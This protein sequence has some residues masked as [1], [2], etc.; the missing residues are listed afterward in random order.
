MVGL[1]VQGYA[2]IAR[3]KDGVQTIFFM[4]KSSISEKDYFIAWAIFFV[5]ALV[6][7]MIAGFIGG[8]IIGGAM[9]VAG[10][11]PG[12][13]R[14]AGAMVGFL[15]SLPISYITFRFVVGKFVVEKVEAASALNNPTFPQP[16]S[17]PAPTPAPQPPQNQVQPPPSLAA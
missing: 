1:A 15:L 8:A 12:A 16:Y 5:C 11:K 10:A 17:A 9:G 2:W 6:G 14:A 4:K 3:F 7:G 13:I